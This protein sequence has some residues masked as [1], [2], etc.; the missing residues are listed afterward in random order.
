MKTVKT[1]RMKILHST[2]AI[3]LP[4]IMQHGLLAYPDPLKDRGHAEPDLIRPGVN[5]WRPD[6]RHWWSEK[7][8][9]KHYRDDPHVVL[10]IDATKLQPELLKNMWKHGCLG[11]WSRY[12]ADI[13]VAAITVSELAFPGLSRIRKHRRSDAGCVIR[14][15]VSPERIADIVAAQ[16]HQSRLI[17]ARSN[18]AG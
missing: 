1:T 2:P 17:S 13:P 8:P 10:E 9:I 12:F 3:N 16:E 15:M 4:S 7:D 18:H 14:V 11:V 6:H 5:L